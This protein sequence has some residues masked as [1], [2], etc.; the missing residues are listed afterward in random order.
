MLKLKLQYFGH[1]MWRTDSLEKTLMLGK[2]EGR[3]R[4]G[5][6]KMR[7]LDGITDSMDMNLS[8]LQELLSFLH[9]SV[10]KSS[11]C[12]AGDPGLI[13][14]SGRS[15]GEGNGNSLQ[16]SCLENPMDRGAWQAKVHGIIR[17][18]HDLAT[19]PPPPWLAVGNG[20]RSLAC[21]SPHGPKELDTNEQLNCT[22]LRWPSGKECAC[23][24]RRC[25]LGF[26]PWVWKIPC[27]RAWQPTL[28]FL[29]GESHGQRSLVGYSPWGCKESGT[30]EQ[31][32]MWIYFC[33]QQESN[34]GM[35]GWKKRL[36][37][38]RS[39]KRQA[40]LWNIC[41]KA[42]GTCAMSRASAGAALTH[43]CL[44]LPRGQT[45]GPSLS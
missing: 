8:K 38:E 21:Y 4:K 17:V 45:V 20:Q 13:P 5:W 40:Q 32:Y 1:L 18:G 10:G 2:I 41:K 37:Q 39:C 7:W 12:N 25:R 22:E 9:S 29:P 14:G 28:I 43:K 23:Q 33:F 16:Y 36:R 44:R 15:P 27:R 19:K 34:I 30:T 3:Q 11:A 35:P 42:G 24:W 6:P 26:N 31:A